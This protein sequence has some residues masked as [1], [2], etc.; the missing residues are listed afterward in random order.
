MLIYTRIVLILAAIGIVSTGITGILNIPNTPIIGLLSL[1]MA[2]A[3]GYFWVK[4]WI[5][6]GK[7]INIT[8][9]VV[10]TSSFT[11]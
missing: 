5:A 4:D 1:L 6:L 2:V 8:E 9:K 11:E 7:C 3:V 10:K